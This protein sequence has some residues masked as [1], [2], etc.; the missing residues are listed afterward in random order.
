M[1]RVGLAGCCRCFSGNVMFPCLTFLDIVW[2][3]ECN[4]LLPLRHGVQN[5]D[6]QHV[7]RKQHIPKSA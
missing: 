4:P 2:L 3:L 7:A 5:P 1:L 6:D